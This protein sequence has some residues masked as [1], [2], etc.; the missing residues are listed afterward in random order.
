MCLGL[1]YSAI[2]VV[3]V[4]FDFRISLFSGRGTNFFNGCYSIW[5]TIDMV[6]LSCLVN[7]L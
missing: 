4:N 3:R 6:Y 1:K 7:T 2:G 5:L